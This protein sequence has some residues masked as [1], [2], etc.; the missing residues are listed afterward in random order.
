MAIT[1]EVSV[2]PPD[3]LG[4]RQVV[5]NGEPKGKVRSSEELQ[6]FL[7][8]AGLSSEHPIHWLGGGDTVWPYR[9]IRQRAVG[10]VMFIGFLLPAG[11]LLWIGWLDARNALSFGERLAGFTLLAAGLFVFLAAGATVDY[12]HKRVWRYSGAIVLAGVGIVCLGSCSLIVL[13]S[14]EDFNEWTAFAIIFLV[15]SVAA[16]FFLIRSRAWKGVRNPG[17]IAIGAVVPVVLAGI[18]LAYT[19]VY[20]PYVT[21][22]LI[23]SGAEFKEAHL[24]GKGESMYVAVRLYV[25]NAG[26]IPVYILGSIYWVHGGPANL[27]SENG[28]TDYKRI[29]DGEFVTPAGRVLNP[30]EEITQDAVVEIAHAENAENLKYEAIR[31]QTEVYVIRKDRMRLP[32]DQYAQSRKVLKEPDWGEPVNAQYRN[33]SKISNSSEILNVTRGDQRITV[34][35]V[36]DGEWSH[37]EA[38]VTPPGVRIN[39]NP[40]APGYKQKLISR[41]GF[42]VVRGSVAQMPYKELLEKARST[43]NGDSGASSGR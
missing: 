1:H 9:V 21:T 27:V 28:P 38:A 26:Q 23:M 6:R 4:W 34:W 10:V 14:G 35:R 18:N 39:F 31:V 15:W 19:Q 8:D 13:Q 17:R 24:S 36:S 32:V 41:Y 33:E 12:W 30:G 7:K 22:P 5:I 40:E 43:E 20:V 3:A 42:D 16:G 29:Y 25:K 11:L 2:E 37:V